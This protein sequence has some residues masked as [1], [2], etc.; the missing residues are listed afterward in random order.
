MYLIFVDNECTVFFK[1]GG[2]NDQA[3][4]DMA[5]LLIKTGITPVVDMKRM[6]RYQKT[7][8]FL[9][10]EEQFRNCLIKIYPSEYQHWE[11]EKSY[12]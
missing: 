10:C 7:D 12:D 5:I 4:I 1:D 6:G 2:F 3:M 9:K 8:A 11:F